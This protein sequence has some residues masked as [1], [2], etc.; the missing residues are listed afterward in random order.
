MQHLQFFTVGC[1]A[2]V[3]SRGPKRPSRSSCILRSFMFTFLG[4]LSRR[5]GPAPFLE[6][7][8]APDLFGSVRSREP[9]TRARPCERELSFV[10]SAIAHCP[11]AA[12][13]PISEQ[14]CA[15]MHARLRSF[16]CYGTSANAWLRNAATPSARSCVIAVEPAREPLDR[17]VRV[18]AFGRI[19]HRLDDWTAIGPRLTISAAH[20]PRRRANPFDPSA[21]PHRRGRAQALPRPRKYVRRAPCG[22]RPMRRNDGRAAASPTSPAPC[23]APSRASPT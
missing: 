13:G 19:D 9:P 6:A 17:R 20:A 11:G 3:R 12:C 15:R 4:V 1:V 22:A 10:W 2:A 18:L 14:S 23:P 8:L 7:S 5:I 21:Q 16:S